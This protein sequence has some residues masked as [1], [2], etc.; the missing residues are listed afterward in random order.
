M[1]TIVE[2]LRNKAIRF[3]SIITGDCSQPDSWN[4]LP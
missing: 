2:M 1:E 3:N 4:E